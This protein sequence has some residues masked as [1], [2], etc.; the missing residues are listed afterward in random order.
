[1]FLLLRSW[2]RL[3]RGFTLIELLVVIAIIAILIGLLLPAVQKVREA[4]ARAQSGNNLHQMALAV[5]NFNDHSG[6][7]PPAIGWHPQPVPPAT[8]VSGGIHGTAFFFLL[9]DLEQDN[10]FKSSYQQGSS[11]GGYST[12]T[13]GGGTLNYP[14]EIPNGIYAYRADTLSRQ[15]NRVKT[16]VGPGDPTADNDTWSLTSVSYL[17]NVRVFD[18]RRRI[19]QIPDG[20]S[21]TLLFAEGYQSCFS[22]VV[23]NSPWSL[24]YTSRD[25]SYTSQESTYSYSSPSYTAYQA[26]PVFD[27]VPGMTFQNHPPGDATWVSTSNGGSS[28]SCD[29]RLPQSH[30]S[31]SLLTALADGS[32]KGVSSGVSPGTFAAAITPDGGEVLGNDW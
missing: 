16:F 30:S 29:A 20:T 3:K 23:V 6:Y 14:W 22:E 7:L 21:N 10:I 26:G 2:R 27:V 11:Q 19:D 31:G 18:G 25:G 28:G 8:D 4:A 17:A 32:V 5:H 12:W 1:M 15:A 24:V 9:N 13:Q